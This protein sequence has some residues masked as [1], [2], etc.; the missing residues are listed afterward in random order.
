MKA[1]ELRI[2]NYA[3]FGNNANSTTEEIVAINNT[4]WFGEGKKYWLETKNLEGELLN[5]FQPIPLTEEW[6]L[7]FGFNND[8]KPDYIGIDVRSGGITTDF[9][10][11]KPLSKGEWQKY[12]TFDL[13]QNRFVAF[14]YVHELQNLYFA[15]TGQELTINN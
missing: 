1:H 10:L 14:S 11:T 13:A 4:D 3:I 5:D 12:Y 9:V 7:K 8:Y 15:I 2:G 6:L